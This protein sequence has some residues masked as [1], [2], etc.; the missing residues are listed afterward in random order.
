LGNVRVTGRRG[1]VGVHQVTAI[2]TEA[3]DADDRLEVLLALPAPWNPG[4][5]TLELLRADKF[6]EPTDQVLDGIDPRYARLEFSL[7]PECP[8]DLDCAVVAAC[9]SDAFSM[10]EPVINYLAKDY[11][12]FKRVIFDRLAL[13]MP[14][15]RERHVPDVGVALIEIFAYVG[16]PQLP[17]GCGFDR[18]VFGHGPATHF[19][20]SSCATGGLHDA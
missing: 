8:A 4:S 3:K 16:D 13:V 20:A 17:P 7:H 15:W 10:D 19:G 14:E 1:R 6:E 2:H 5:Y 11:A 12:S 9:D 18:G